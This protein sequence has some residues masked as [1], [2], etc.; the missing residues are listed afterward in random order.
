M[1]ESRREYMS[2]IELIHMGRIADLDFGDLALGRF[3]YEGIETVEQ[4]LTYS[5][6]DLLD[7]RWLG[8]KILDDIK[9]ALALKGLSLRSEA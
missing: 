2:D 5:E 9:R 8:P 3:K 6:Q 1:F 4:L 7:I